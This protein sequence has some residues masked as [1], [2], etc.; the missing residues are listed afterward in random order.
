MGYNYDN[1]H[2]YDSYQDAL[3]YGTLQARKWSR[4]PNDPRTANDPG[5]ANDPQIGL[6]MIPW[7]EMIGSSVIKE[8]NELK[9]LDWIWNFIYFILLIT[10]QYVITFKRFAWKFYN[11]KTYGAAAQCNRTIFL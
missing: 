7:L 6:Q 8:W 4:P 10:H 5:S 3:V 9:N 1:Y 2:F 11:L